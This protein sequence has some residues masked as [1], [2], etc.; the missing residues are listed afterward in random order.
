MLSPVEREIVKILAELKPRNEEE[1]KLAYIEVL[2]RIGEKYPYL[3]KYSIFLKILKRIEKKLQ[4]AIEDWTLLQRTGLFDPNGKLI[5]DVNR[6]LNEMK[7]IIQVYG[8]SLKEVVNGGEEN[9]RRVV[10]RISIQDI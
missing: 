1:L 3:F 4:R 7:I 9:V 10:A 5:F 6:V 8:L 2:R